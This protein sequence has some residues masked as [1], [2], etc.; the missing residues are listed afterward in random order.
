MIRPASE[1]S[2]GSSWFWARTVRCVVGGRQHVLIFQKTTSE[3]NDFPTRRFPQ[4][5]LI[6]DN[7]SQPN[8]SSEITDFPTRRFLQFVLTIVPNNPVHAFL[9][10]FV[11][12]KPS[13]LRKYPWETSTMLSAIPG[14][15]WPTGNVIKCHQS[16]RCCPRHLKL[17]SGVQWVYVCGHMCKVNIWL[18]DCTTHISRWCQQTVTPVPPWAC[19]G[20][21]ETWPIHPIGFTAKDRKSVV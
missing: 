13:N 1:E 8:P 11:Q 9:Y 16:L 4:F 19:S 7:R 3:I 12:D 6:I 15:Q 17:T 18:Y 14:L 2:Y 20:Q 10:W 21:L 5:V